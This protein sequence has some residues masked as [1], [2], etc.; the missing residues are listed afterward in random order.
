MK[1]RRETSSFLYEYDRQLLYVS[2]IHYHVLEINYFL[3]FLKNTIDTSKKMM[4]Y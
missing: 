4:Y 2:I 1:K 3:F